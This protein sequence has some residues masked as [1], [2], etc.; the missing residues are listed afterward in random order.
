MTLEKIFKNLWTQYECHNPL[1]KQIHD[2]VE[3]KEL[4]KP[5]VNDHIAL[6]TFN[7]PRVNLEVI[8][9]FFLDL[10]Y[11][12]K[13]QYNFEEKML[14]AKH[15]EKEGYPRIFISELRLEE[16]SPFIRETVEGILEQVPLMA[17][18][19][20]NFLWSGCLWDMISSEDYECIRHESEY[21]AWLCVFG[22]RANHFTISVNHLRCFELASLVR[23]LKNN[24]VLM[25]KVGG[26][27]KGDKRITYFEQASTLACNDVVDFSDVSMEVPCCYYEFSQRYELPSGELFNGFVTTNAD[28]IF[29]STDVQD[30]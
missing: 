3:T 6:R 28:K 8:A 18:V 7:H 9:K 29:E 27:I 4:G 14:N 20:P 23:F 19:R 25:N 21:A 10:G 5:I 26:E 22:F 13:G 17:T 2:L 12:E 15:Y 16:C 1:I 30:K 24:E 11:E